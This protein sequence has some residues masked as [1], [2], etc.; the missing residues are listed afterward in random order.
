MF[1]PFDRV[2]DSAERGIAAH[3][4][5]SNLER[6]RLV[7]G[8]GEDLRS[9]MFSHGH[10]FAGDRRLIDEGVAATHDA[11]DRDPSAWKHHDLIAFA[12]LIEA[13]LDELAVPPRPD[14]ARQI[15]DQLPD[16]IPA[17]RYGQRLEGLC[18]QHERGD[19]ERRDD[20]ADHERSY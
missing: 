10:G 11:I 8:A 16:R 5:R 14:A 13:D 7:D 17:S 4:H 18:D 15:L 9:R 3:S 2:D 6:A 1:G 19:D 20:F 12:Q